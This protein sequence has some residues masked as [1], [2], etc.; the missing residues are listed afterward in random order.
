MARAKEISKLCESNLGTSGKP[1]AE[2]MR[3]KP[4]KHKSDP[5]RDHDWISDSIML[6][7]KDSV[8]TQALQHLETQV[9]ELFDRKKASPLCNVTL[10]NIDYTTD[11]AHIIDMIYDKY[12]DWDV[13]R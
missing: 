8:S 11:L 1:K 6:E 7:K 12:L 4:Y 13:I 3:T 5:N 9:R 10:H 2:V